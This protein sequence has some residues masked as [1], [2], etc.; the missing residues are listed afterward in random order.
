MQQAYMLRPLTDMSIQYP[1]LPGLFNKL[2][3]KE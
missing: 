1:Y 2:C 3:Q